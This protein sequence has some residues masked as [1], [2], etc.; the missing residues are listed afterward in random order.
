M[1]RLKHIL[2]LM[3]ISQSAFSSNFY[4]FIKISDSPE[5]YGCDQFLT[6]SECDQII[7][8]AKPTLKRSSVVDA[9]SLKVVM[10]SRRTSSGTFLSPYSQLNAIQKIREA[11]EEITSL[12][13]ENGEP[14]QVLYYPTGG[15]YQPH[16]DY[17]DKNEE[18]GILHSKRGGQ[19]VATLLVYLNTP[20]EGGETVFPKLKIK[21]NPKKGR[22][23]LFYNISSDG[24]VD[25]RTLHGGAPV[26]SGEKWIATLWIREETFR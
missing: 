2:A 8:M 21:I 18:G 17:F 22:A 14:L 7:D 6:D 23:V 3:L 26:L 16:Y 1:L 5:V 25:P 10:D 19:R 9:K 11:G 4:E 15:E 13:K 20:E 24:T 12:P